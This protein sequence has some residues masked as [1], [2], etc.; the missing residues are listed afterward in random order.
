MKKIYD[1]S[2]KL[3]KAFEQSIAVVKIYN[4]RKKLGE[5]IVDSVEFHAAYESAIAFLKMPPSADNYFPAFMRMASHK[6]KVQKTMVDKE[7]FAM[8]ECPPPC[9]GR[10]TIAH[11][12]S[13]K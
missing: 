7:F 10:V 9:T 2:I 5:N 12:G 8:I 11:M 1:T 4:E 6:H 13:K 3:L